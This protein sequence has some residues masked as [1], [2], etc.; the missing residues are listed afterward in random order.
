MPPYA[1]PADI[2]PFPAEGYAPLADRIAGLLGTRN[3]VLLIQA[4]AVVALEAAALSLARRGVRAL[5]IVTSLYGAWFG[6]WLRRGGATVQNLVAPPGHPV[7]VD[8]VAAALA[9]GRF[10][11]L[12]LVHAESASGILNPLPEIAALARA[13]GALVVVDA[14]ASV[15]GHPV[16]VDAL[17]LDVVVIGPQKA[18]GGQAGTSAVAVSAAAWERMSPPG[19][20]PSILSL[21]DQRALWLQ[22]GRGAL[23]GTPSALEFHS[24]AAT[25][26]RVGAEGMGAIIARHAAAARAARAG[27]LALTGR[28]HVPAA[29]ASN[30]V[31]AVPLA[32]PATCAAVLAALPGG[33]GIGPGVGPG[34]EALLRL[35]HTGPRAGLAP[36]LGDLWTLAQALGRPDAEAAQAAARAAHAAVP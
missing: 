12:A 6:G 33:T 30:L 35:N 25:L 10:D 36:V 32:D 23:P 21:A 28:A 7:T 17:G 15:G 4:E 31:T 24:L 16:D 9:G 34:T 11:V 19:A 1:P 18:L 26:D 29:Q 27:V 20:A 2:P 22:T 8:A 13:H 3:D 5:N 14:V